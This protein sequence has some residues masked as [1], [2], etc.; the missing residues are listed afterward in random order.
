MM[1]KED[2][3]RGDCRKRRTIPIIDFPS[4]WAWIER[5]LCSI[6]IDRRCGPIE[7]KEKDPFEKAK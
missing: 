3:G 1:R 2:P 7:K 5:H 4:S 6:M